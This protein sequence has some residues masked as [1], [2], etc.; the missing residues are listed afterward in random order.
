MSGGQIL[1]N[2]TIDSHELL[3]V[4]FGLNAKEKY[5]TN[6]AS[7]VPDPK[8]KEY[9]TYP[10]MIQHILVTNIFKTHEIKKI[11]P[12][13]TTKKLTSLRRILKT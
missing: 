8:I 10:Y 2:S 6:E 4:L 12:K 1:P 3:M 5:N 9:L 13:Y 11:P 7:S